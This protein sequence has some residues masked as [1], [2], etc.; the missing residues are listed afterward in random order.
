MRLIH[1]LAVLPFIGILGGI[2]FANR[3]EPYVLGLPTSLLRCPRRPE[4][5]SWSPARS[6]CS[7]SSSN[8]LF[9]IILVHSEARSRRAQRRVT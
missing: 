2:S 6:V 8:Y 1:M 7:A 5:G 9:H 4:C 3:V